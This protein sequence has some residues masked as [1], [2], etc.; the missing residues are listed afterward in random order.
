[1]NH[2]R[3]NYVVM[4]GR[5]KA[6]AVAGPYRC[7]GD[8]YYWGGMFGFISQ[9]PRAETEAYIRATFDRVTLITWHGDK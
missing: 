7:G 9:A 6:A 1:M 5:S 2:V 4:I 8:F 3:D